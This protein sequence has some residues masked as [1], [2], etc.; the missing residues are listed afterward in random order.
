MNANTTN[1]PSPTPP[2]RTLSNPTFVV[3]LYRYGLTFIVFMGIA[4]NLASIVT[5]KRPNLRHTSTCCLFLAVAISDT[6]FLLVTIFDVVEVAIVQGPIFLANYDNFCRFRWFARG[7]TR[8]CSAWL[9][10]IVAVDRWFRSR[11]PYQI[12]K[13]CTRLNVLIATAVVMILSCA[14]H[15]HLLSPQNV[16]RFF[17][18]IP[19]LACGPANPMSSYIYFFFIQWPIIQVRSYSLRLDICVLLSFILGHSHLHHS[20]CIDPDLWL[21]NESYHSPRKET[22]STE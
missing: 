14:L 21:A 20:I 11:F 13:I 16:R 9:L 15:S 12:N 19:S 17:P 8:F 22:R 7:F 18:G 1:A 3:L 4:G 10:V 5:F 6:M 2:F